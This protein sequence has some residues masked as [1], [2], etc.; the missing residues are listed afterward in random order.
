MNATATLTDGILRYQRERSLD[1]VPAYKAGLQLRLT[2]GQRVY[3]A[4]S[5]TEL[6]LYFHVT[7]PTDDVTRSE[8]AVHFDL[9]GRLTKVCEPNCYWRRSLSHRTLF[10]QKLAREQGGG[11]EWRVLHPDAADNLT[12]EMNAT[13][14][15]VQEQFAGGDAEI[16]F[17]KPSVDEAR[18]AIAPYLAKA[19]R[20][21]VA[22]A[23]AD[24]DRF[25]SIYGRVA[26]LPPDQYNALVLQATQGC[27]YNHCLFCTLYRG[28]Q[29]H[30]K[31]PSEFRRHMHDVIAYHGESLRARRSI[32]LGE[33]NALAQPQLTLVEIFQE[34]HKA[35]EFPP[36]TQD[37]V[38]A[39]WWLGHERR[40]D[41]VCSF[42]DAFTPPHRPA[43]DFRELR[44]LGLRRLYIGMES[45]DDNLLRW[46]RK[47]ATSEALWAALKAILDAGVHVGVIVLLGA[48]GHKFYGQHVRE[49]VRVL[50]SLPL[51][52]G[53]YI[54][55]SPLRI[56][57]LSD[58]PA[59]ARMHGV[60]PL[61]PEEMDRQGEEI[62]KGL[63]FAWPS[64]PP[65]VARYE[66][67]T[68]VY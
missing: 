19:A 49:T 50:N 35:F 33:A 66:L 26:V 46:L 16:E 29:S 21:D 5:P 22:T 10:K 13:I 44:S 48:G 62:R 51:R 7:E 25:R 56:D 60:E 64:S 34:L 3:A 8:F 45:G 28:V 47:P 65:Y 40:F 59:R 57:P 52:K 24:V 23:H 39:D 43:D 4:L 9:E 12:A 68:F 32:F 30:R 27:T 18:A 63:R 55:F 20:F 42:M 67:E 54:Y 58:Y 53:D 1:H 37:R 2:S 61:T 6:A 17:G 15:I 14:A 31:T 36:P 38:P 11:I 41:G